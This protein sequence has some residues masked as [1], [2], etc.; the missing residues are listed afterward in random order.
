MGAASLR[1]RG[2]LAGPPQKEHPR[3]G[4]RARAARSACSSG[5][6]VWGAQPPAGGARSPSEGA[7]PPLRVTRVRRTVGGR[8]GAAPTE[9]TSEGGWAGQSRAARSSGMGVWGAQPPAGDARSPSEGVGPPSGSRACGGPL[10]GGPLGGVGAAPPQKE[11]P[12]AGG[13]ARAARSACSSGMGVWGAQPP[14]GDAR[15]PSE[16]AGPPLRVT[17]VGGPLGGVGAQPPQKE[18]PRAGGRARAAQRARPGWGCGGR[19]P[20]QETRGRPPRG[21]DR[22]QGHARAADRWGADRWGAWGRSPHRKNIRGRVGGP[23]P[24]AARA[25]PGWGVGAAPPREGVRRA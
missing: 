10:G 16:G 17:R 6:G 4:G 21:P 25:R 19:S 1:T 5:M 24:R 2:N 18:H 3:A 15:S 7:G 8:G 20:P 9:R 14:A 11:H 12:R 23:E 13:R 22:P